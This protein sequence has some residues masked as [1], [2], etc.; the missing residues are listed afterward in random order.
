MLEAGCVP[1]YTGAPN[2][3]DYAPGK[4]CYINTGDFNSPKDLA[5]YLSA[6]NEDDKAYSAFHAWRGQ[7]SGTPYRRFME[8]QHVHP[9]IR[10]CEAVQQCA[11]G[12]SPP[13]LCAAADSSPPSLRR[14]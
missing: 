5:D 9:F 7:S 4:N 3:E 6:L 12:L 1:V 14:T 2:I 13:R 10:L 8:E 11:G